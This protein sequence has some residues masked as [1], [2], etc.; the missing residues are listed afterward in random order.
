MD[1]EIARRADSSF[2]YR[3]KA[4]TGDIEPAKAH[5][6]RRAGQIPDSLFFGKDITIVSAETE[7][8]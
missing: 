8:G 6:L 5:P 3:S 1:T 2:R 7:V 4:A